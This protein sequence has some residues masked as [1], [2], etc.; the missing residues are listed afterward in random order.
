MVRPSPAGSTRTLRRSSQKGPASK[1]ASDLHERPQNRLSAGPAANNTTEPRLAVGGFPAVSGC[2]IYRSLVGSTLGVAL[3]RAPRNTRG[4]PASGM[5]SGSIRLG[6]HRHWC[7]ISLDPRSIIPPERK[8]SRITRSS[9]STL[10]VAPFRRACEAHWYES[11]V[12]S[13]S[14]IDPTH[15]RLAEV[16]ARAPFRNRR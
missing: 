3:I 15:H 1:S 12:A 8:T 2:A 7:S 4:T 14:T 11:A 5:A 16:K 13:W 9:S 6:C 10:G